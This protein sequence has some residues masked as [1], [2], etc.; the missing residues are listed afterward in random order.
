MSLGIKDR[1]I[2]IHQTGNSQFPHRT[3][4]SHLDKALYF[5]KVSPKGHFLRDFVIKHDI[6]SVYMNIYFY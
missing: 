3:S 5:E 4:Y 6:K 1:I 2:N